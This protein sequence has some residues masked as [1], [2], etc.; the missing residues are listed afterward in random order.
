M[1]KREADYKLRGRTTRRQQRKPWSIIL[2]F[3]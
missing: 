1:L 2:K 3:S